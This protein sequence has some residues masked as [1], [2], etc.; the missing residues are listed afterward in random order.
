MVVNGMPADWR[1]DGDKWL[2]F[3]ERA[4]VRQDR[5]AGTLESET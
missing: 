1:L 3:V 4:S 5:Q 2:A